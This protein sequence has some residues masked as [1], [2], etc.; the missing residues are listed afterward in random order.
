[1]SNKELVSDLLTRL[2]D[3][4]SLQEIAREVEFI[5][6]VREGMAQLERG[7][8]VEIDQ[9]EKMIGSWITK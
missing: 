2:P 7:E 4:V 3:D 9:V 8:G 1:M 5:A 6:G